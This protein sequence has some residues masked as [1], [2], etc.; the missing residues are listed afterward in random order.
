MTS[1][2]EAVDLHKTFP[3]GTHAL[4][5][6]SFRIEQGEFA[7]IM[8]PS[9]SGK[10]T[11]LHILGFLD[12]Q[13]T[14]TYRFRG[15]RLEDMSKYELARVRN[16]E[17]GFVFQSF[18]LLPHASVRENIVLPLYYSNVPVRAWDDRVAHA[19]EAV[20]LSHRT[21]HDAYMLSGGE[22]QRV[23]IARALI[24]TPNLIFADEPTGN[25]DTKAGGV[26]LDI[27][28]ELHVAGHTVVLITHDRS[29]AQQAKRVLYIRD[30]V[31]ERDT[32]SKDI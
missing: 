17:L 22:K 13:T 15:K 21:D 19:I 9:G 1:V 27:M 10:S 3:D 28:H 8:G 7:A 18:N 12:P 24:N 30:G 20:G 11:L 2:I 29:V 16:E 32:A 5:G 31:L 25:L 14:G 26:V 6:V 4:R 23:A